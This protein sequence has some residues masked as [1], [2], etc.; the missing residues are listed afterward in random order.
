MLL[1][2]LAVLTVLVI[3]VVVMVAGPT[4]R[5]HEDCLTGMWVGD[6]AFLRKA[7]LSDM[8]LY[9]SPRAGSQR[10]QGYLIMA[11]AGRN[12]VANQAFDLTMPGGGWRRGLAGHFC[13]QDP[14]SLPAVLD[15]D[16]DFELIPSD[17]VLTTADGSLA[18]HDGERLYAFL[19]KDAAASAAAARALDAQEGED[20]ADPAGPESGGA[21]GEAR[22]PAAEATAAERPDDSPSGGPDDGPSGGLDGGPGGGLDDGRPADEHPDPFEA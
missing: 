16:G 14:R 15:F 8:Q 2:G 13:P 11:D 19:W 4:N 18:L 10:R 7:G 21:A 5:R 12:L 1:G 3:L 6:P 22:A 9:I 20:P 17:V